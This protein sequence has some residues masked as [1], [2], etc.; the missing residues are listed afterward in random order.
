MSENNYYNTFGEIG[1]LVSITELADWLHSEPHN[2]PENFVKNWEP[3]LLGKKLITIF[4][5]DNPKKIN[6]NI[7]KNFTTISKGDCKF[8]LS[9]F[10]RIVFNLAPKYFDLFTTKIIKIDK[11]GQL[12]LK[13]LILK[14]AVPR[15]II[16]KILFIT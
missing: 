15:V 9:L 11:I 5:N 12:F 2:C 7:F 6:N 3:N 14:T 8:D 13:R 16:D 1:S 10:I 4:D